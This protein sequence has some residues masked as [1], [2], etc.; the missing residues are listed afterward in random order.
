M[1]E[2]PKGLCQCGCGGK[3]LISPRDNKANGHVKGEPRRYLN[4]HFNRSAKGKKN[5]SW[6]GGRY[7][8][9]KGYPL[10]RN[11][12]HPRAIAGGYVYEHILKAENAL[13]KPLPLN[14]AVHHHDVKQLVVCQ[15]QGYHMLIHQRKRAYEACGQANWRK[16]W[17]CKR[18]DNPLR[19]CGKGRKK[20][21]QECSTQYA[22]NRRAQRE[23]EAH[24]KPT[25][26]PR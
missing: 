15:D 6:D 3:T 20:Y 7:V 19:L 16:C 17:I 26:N 25:P 21:H 1:S 8:D 14:V 11:Q 12:D 13:G 10:V 22:R 2:I 9:K 23:E 5:P 4:H 24:G 18:Y